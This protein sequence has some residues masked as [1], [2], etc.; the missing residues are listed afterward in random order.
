MYFDDVSFDPSRL[1]ATVEHRV[2]IEFG[3]EFGQSLTAYEAAAEI[4]ARMILP[5]RSSIAP[6][7]HGASD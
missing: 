1:V 4:P 7:G 2:P 5:E 3:K 6:S